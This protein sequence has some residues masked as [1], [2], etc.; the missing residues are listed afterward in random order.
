MK[1]LSS[2]VGLFLLGIAML[3]AQNDPKAAEIMSSSRQKY[4]SLK[5]LTSN[6]KYT[7]ENKSLKDGNTSRSGTMKIKGKKYRV[8]F[9]EQEVICDGSTIWL[10]MKPEKEVNISEFDPEES[11]SLDR[12]YKIYEKETKSRYDKEETIGTAIYHKISL[13]SINKNSDYSRVEVW[14]NKKT[15]MMEKALIFQRNGAMVKYELTNIKTDT[16]I[17]DAEFVFNK[18]S[19][20]GFEIVDLR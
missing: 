11:L 15:L 10:I 9:S 18:A 1:L 19:F 3:F 4:N 12:M 17:T 8:S 6:F 14:V 20:P 7:L 5:D 2:S 16:G 13:F